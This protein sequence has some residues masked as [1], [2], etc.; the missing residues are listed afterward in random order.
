MCCLAR[1]NYLAHRGLEWKIRSSGDTQS[2]RQVALGVQNEAGLRL[3]E[4]CHE[5]MLV[6]TNILFQQPKR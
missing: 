2:N 5:N 3:I 6:I 1:S 4:S